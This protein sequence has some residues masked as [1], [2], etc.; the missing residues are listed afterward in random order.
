MEGNSGR[1]NAGESSREIYNAAPELSD[2][3]SSGDVSK[4]ERKRT[5][6]LS[7]DGNKSESART[8]GDDNRAAERKQSG[9]PAGGGTGGLP[10]M[11]RLTETYGKIAEETILKEI[12]Y[13]E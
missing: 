7:S 1:G 13:S 5:S 9:I 10:K 11:V 2:E 3:S 6:E 4:I 12:I 8:D